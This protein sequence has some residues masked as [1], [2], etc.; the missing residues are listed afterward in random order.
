ME[1]NY[2]KVNDMEILSKLLLIV[3]MVRYSGYWLVAVVNYSSYSSYNS[4]S[5]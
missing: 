4:Y 1:Q 3:L 5:S 2:D